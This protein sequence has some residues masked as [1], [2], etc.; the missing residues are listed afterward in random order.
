MTAT[1]LGSYPFRAGLSRTVGWFTTLFPV[2]L[3]VESTAP[4]ALLQSVKEQLRAIPDRGFGY[5]VLRYLRGGEAARR[6]PS[7]PRCPPRE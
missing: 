3:A 6:R 5:G 2:A 7:S 1:G 4:G